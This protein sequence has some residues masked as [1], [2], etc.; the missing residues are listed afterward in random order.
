[1]RA[2]PQLQLDRPTLRRFPA[3]WPLRQIPHRSAPIA[4]DPTGP[5]QDLKRPTP[6]E[7]RRVEAIHPLDANGMLCCIASPSCR[8]VMRCGGSPFGD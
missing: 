6:V 2:A 8:E 3:D 5:T 1:M 7:L 4:R